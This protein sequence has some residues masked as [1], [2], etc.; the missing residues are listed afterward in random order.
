MSAIL[1]VRD[2][3][4]TFGSLVAAHDINVA[5]PP[6]QTV[7]IIGANG[8]GKTTFVNMITGHLRPSKGAIFFDGRDITGR[9][10][11][12]ITRLGIARSFQVPQVFASLTVFE[13]MCIATA[14]AHA[15]GGL[16]AQALTP[17]HSPD[18]VA[19]AEAALEL[20]RIAELPP[21]AGGDA[22]AGRPQAPR[23]RHGGGRRAARAAARRADQ[24]HLDRRKIRS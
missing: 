8:A 7:G 16:L 15:A 3:E 5:V 24:R 13:N 19:E 6:L 14:V 20:F 18:T 23:H 21:S 17:L 4:K 1:A 11:R 12:E 9:P 22:A 2:L 10:S